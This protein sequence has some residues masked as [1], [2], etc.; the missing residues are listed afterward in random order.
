MMSHERAPGIPTERYPEPVLQYNVRRD[1]PVVTSTNDAFETAFETVSVGTPVS[2]VFEQFTVEDASGFVGFRTALVRGES[3]SV[4]IEDDSTSRVYTIR[5]VPVDG[6]GFLVFTPLDDIPAAVETTGV[7]H[8]ASVLSH[9]LRNPLDVAKAHLHAARETGDSEHFD[10]VED[11]HDRMGRIIRDVLT[12]ARG[13]TAVT[14]TDR[15]QLERAVEDAW[16]S[17]ETPAAALEYTDELPAATADADRVRRLFENLFRNAVEHGGASVTVRV[18]ALEDGFYVVDDGPGIPSGELDT[19]LDPGY[20]TAEGG[21]GLGLAI[22]ASI[23]EAHDWT[24]RVT[25]GDAGGAR[26]EV[27]F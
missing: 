2:T 8:V 11:A 13:Q 26:F 21:T 10:A 12:L 1:E 22:V 23:V 27:R 15:I 25:D 6:M 3:A 7:G 19:V 18:G 9:D 24:L 20:S 16:Q 17:V 4:Y 14:P 5:S